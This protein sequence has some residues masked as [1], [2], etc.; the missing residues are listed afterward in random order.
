MTCAPEFACNLGLRGGIEWNPTDLRRSPFGLDTVHSTTDLPRCLGGP[1]LRLWEY[2]RRGG[3]S[4]QID[5]HLPAELPVLLV[6]VVQ[7][8]LFGAAPSAFTTVLDD[9]GA[10]SSVVPDSCSWYAMSAVGPHVLSGPAP[11]D[12]SGGVRR[13]QAWA[14]PDAA[15]PEPSAVAELAAAALCALD[16]PAGERLTTGSG[17][18]ALEVVRERAAGVRLDVPAATPLP[19]QNLGPQESRWL[20]LLDD[21]GLGLADRVDPRDPGTAV[22]RS[23][24]RMLHRA[25]AREAL[26]DWR[27]HLRLGEFALLDDDLQ[28]AAARW[29]WS[30]ALRPTC[31]A[32]RN[33]ALVD[34]LSGRLDLAAVRYLRAHRRDP[35]ELELAVEAVGA[36]IAAGRAGDSVAVLDRAARAGHDGSV[37]YWLLN[38]ELGLALHRLTDVDVALAQGRRCA[39]A[40]VFSLW[41]DALTGTAS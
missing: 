2:D 3:W 29:A 32:E 11:P 38:A 33:L 18:A 9:A 37:R 23:W 34:A 14:I 7:R 10:A 17:W 36:L 27:V 20:H 12:S 8:R 15:L 19:I 4:F 39:D 26:G 6:A 41:L 28:E 24:E 16:D 5:L 40:G 21:A 25:R 30:D 22:G 13:W 31:W 1:R 35:S